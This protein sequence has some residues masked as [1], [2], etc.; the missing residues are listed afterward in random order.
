VFDC[1]LQQRLASPQWRPLPRPCVCL[2]LFTRY[3]NDLSGAPWQHASGCS[4]LF[5]VECAGRK[6]WS[7]QLPCYSGFRLGV[8]SMPWLACSVHFRTNTCFD[9]LMSL[10]SPAHT[11][12]VAVTSDSMCRLTF[13]GHATGLCVW[14]SCV[15]HPVRMW[16]R[17]EKG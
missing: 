16:C 5:L 8:T 13:S 4:L 6:D 3:L 14:M 1:R 9:W 2:R 10:C 17:M 15:P 7:Q 11:A 12:Y